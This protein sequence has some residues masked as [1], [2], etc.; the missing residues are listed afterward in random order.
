MCV[1]IINV[2]KPWEKDNICLDALAILI[3]YAWAARCKQ[4]L[5]ASLPGRLI[6]QFWNEA[7]NLY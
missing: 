2:Y 4:W 7:W 6:Q 3:A 1:Y 5:W